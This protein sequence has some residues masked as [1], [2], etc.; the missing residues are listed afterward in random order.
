MMMISRMDIIVREMKVDKKN[1]RQEKKRVVR[2]KINRSLSTTKRSMWPIVRVEMCRKK[3]VV[4][5]SHP[6]V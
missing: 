2:I 5:Q 6:I 3:Q 4:L 1:E